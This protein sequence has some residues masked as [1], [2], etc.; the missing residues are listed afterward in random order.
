MFS[1]SNTQM[2]MKE[3]TPNVLKSSKFYSY[4]TAI[5]ITRNTMQFPK[6]TKRQ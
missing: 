3:G 6:E 4:L 5:I 2:A 1:L